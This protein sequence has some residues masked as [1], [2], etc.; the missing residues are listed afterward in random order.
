MKINTAGIVMSL[1]LGAA[2]ASGSAAAKDHGRGSHGFQR[3]SDHD[4]HWRDRDG[5]R[6][7][8]RGD[9]DHDRDD[10][11]GRNRAWESWREPRGWDRGRKTGW[12]GDSLPPGQARKFGSTWRRDDRRWRYEREGWRR[13][14]ADDRVFFP[15]TAGRSWPA[16]PIVVRPVP[17]PRP[18]WRW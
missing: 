15:G 18:I 8:R 9:G 13:G 12:R 7:W 6:G 11:R 4:N 1:V 14:D 3:G 10:W 2:L 17:S 16:R 5:D